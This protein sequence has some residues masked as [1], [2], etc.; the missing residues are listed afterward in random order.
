MKAKL[1]FDLENAFDLDDFRLAQKAGKFLEGTKSFHDYLKENMI[2]NPDREL[3][4][5]VYEA[6]VRSFDD[7][8]EYI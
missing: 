7:V 6:F 4:C 3:Y 1:E 5:K 8:R 2:D